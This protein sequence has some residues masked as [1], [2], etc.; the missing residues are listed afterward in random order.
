[1]KTIDGSR[2]RSSSS[3]EELR[4]ARR[5][6]GRPGSPGTPCPPVWLAPLD[7]RRVAWS[8]RRPSWDAR[9]SL[10]IGTRVVWRVSRRWTAKWLRKVI[11]LLRSTT[12]SVGPR[13]ERSQSPSSPALAT[14]AERQTNMTSGGAQHQH[15]LPDATPV[16][17]LQVVDLVEDDHA[18]ALEERGA[19]KQH[20]AQHL[21][22]HDHDGGFG[23]QGRVAG[24]QAHRVRSRR[25]RRALRTSGWTAL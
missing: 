1:M 23:A 11:G 15:L 12:T 14:V 10:N 25:S 24:E 4:P 19:G 17:V 22:R 18:Q 7:D 5:A 2:S 13:T 21:G 3:L 8:N 9:P 20:V 6:E 16:G